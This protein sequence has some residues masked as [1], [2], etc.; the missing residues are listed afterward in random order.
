ARPEVRLQHGLDLVAEREIREAHDAGGHAGLAVA[1]AVAHRRH[2]RHELGLTD[3]AHLLRAARAIHRLA[4]DEDG[5]DDVV[6]RA[7]VVEELVEQI[8]M[9]SP[10]PEM[11]MR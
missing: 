10:L 11:M 9:P 5:G 6:A 7:D 3:R 4:F 2:P 1:A 8:A